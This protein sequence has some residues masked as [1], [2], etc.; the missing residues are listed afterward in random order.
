MTVPN[1]VHRTLLD[2]CQHNP[3]FHYQNYVE[4]K[5]IE[6]R[7]CCCYD[8]KLYACPKY[9]KISIGEKMS[10]IRQQHSCFN[11]FG[12]GHL[13][14][15]CISS[16]RYKECQ[17]PHNSSLHRVKGDSP[18]ANASIQSPLC[19]K[20]T[21]IKSYSATT[22]QQVIL[23]TIIFSVQGYHGYVSL[24]PFLDSGSKIS[25]ITGEASQ[26]L[27][28]SATRNKTMKS[29]MGARTSVCSGTLDIAIHTP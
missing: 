12:R 15:D 28:W 22:S 4:R 24:L 9:S 14:G 23:P 6:A 17:T 5:A 10:F 16:S 18:S 1:S 2:Q 13:L 8:H 26:K 25:F 7:M 19:E 3:A 29:V 27:N 11:C 21:Q 20:W